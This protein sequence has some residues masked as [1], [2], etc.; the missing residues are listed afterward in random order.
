MLY[1]FLIGMACLFPAALYC[2]FLAMVHHRGQPTMIAGEWDFAGVLAALSGFL[3]LGGTTL[4]YAI[5]TNLQN[6][7]L[8]G[9]SFD[10]LR[11]EHSRA[12]AITIA[13]WAGYFIALI[14]GSIGL[15]R[16]RRR[17]TAIYQLS[18]E[19]LDEVL[20]GVLDRLNL[21][22]VRRGPR[23]TLQSEII[24]DG[25]SES[26]GAIEIEGSSAMRHVTLR[27]F[28]IS[29]K[30]RRDIEVELGRDLATANLPASG[31]ST[32]FMTAAGCI[33][34]FMIFLLVTFLIVSRSR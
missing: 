6:Y 13:I 28:A 32:W 5:D 20:P 34:T 25:Q 8:H 1:L 22:Y 2:L 12:D 24:S 31:A 11:A 3:L 10:D 7:W 14:A 15:L 16:M 33:F 29:A 17:C 23:W 26:A 19:E 9:N 4:V 27:W 21:K 18:P 30:L